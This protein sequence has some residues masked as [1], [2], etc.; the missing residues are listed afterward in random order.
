[1]QIPPLTS[2]SLPLP[3]RAALPQRP[4][5]GLAGSVEALPGKPAFP[6]PPALPHVVNDRLPA[7]ALAASGAPLAAAGLSLV[8]PETGRDF[9][10]ST[11]WKGKPY[12]IPV[13]FG[14]LLTRWC[15]NKGNR[16]DL[17]RCEVVKA[18]GKRVPFVPREIR[19]SYQTL[20]GREAHP[21]LQYDPQLQIYGLP[22]Q[23]VTLDL[24]P[25]G[26]FSCA[27]GGVLN[28]DFA[29]QRERAY[30]ERPPTPEEL[31]PMPAEPWMGQPLQ[32][33]GSSFLYGRTPELRARCLEIFQEVC[34]Q[35]AASGVNNGAPLHVFPVPDNKHWTALPTVHALQD[36]MLAL[37]GTAHG[38]ANFLPLDKAILIFVPESDLAGPG[39]ALRH[40]LYHALERKYL[41]DDQKAVIDGCRDEL[42]KQGGP[43]QSVYGYQREEFLTTMAEEFEGE[44]GPDGPAW[45]RANHPRVA[46]FLS[47]VTG[48]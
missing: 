26:I 17:E 6:P 11:T 13:R 34:G 7:G 27:T 21:W 40:E 18:E 46:A 28:V 41:S 22:S 14:G 35:A 24:Q 31:A 20:T 33:P 19:E 8:Q 12:E 23:P 16:V 42:V 36:Q 38:K 5:D 10:V 48:R 1:M 15:A 25:S 37:G 45:L 32:G 9:T 4:V 44:H 39:Y 29:Y 2:A 43:F 30:V 3:R 47:E